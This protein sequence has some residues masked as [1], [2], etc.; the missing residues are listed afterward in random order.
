MVILRL[1]EAQQLRD[2]LEDQLLWPALSA[3]FG[4]QRSELLARLVDAVRKSER[5]TMREASLA[6][7]VTAYEDIAQDLKAF[8]KEQ[9]EQ[10]S[11]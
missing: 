3:F 2:G 7:M 11:Q 4:K 8:A 1:A 10:A 9:L 5:D 6:G